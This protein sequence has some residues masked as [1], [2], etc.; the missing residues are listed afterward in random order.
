MIKSKIPIRKKV[1]LLFFTV[2]SCLLYGQIILTREGIVINNTETGT[3]IGDN[4]PR[5]KPTIFTYRNNSITSVNT[6]G[7][8]LQAGDEGPTPS[9]NNLDGQV[10]TGNN[11]IWNGVNSPVVLTHGLFV[12]YNIN[13]TIKYNYLKNVPYGIIFKSG[14]DAGQNMTFTSGGCAYNICKNGKFA[15]RLKGINGVHVYNN[16]FYNDDGSGWYFIFVSANMDRPA[17]SPSTG[18]KIFNNLFY[19]TTLFPMIKIESGCLEGFECD[20]NVYWCTSGEPKFMIDD[21]PTSWAEWRALGYDTHSIIANPNFINTTDLVPTTRLNYGKNLGKEWESGLSTTASW[22]PGTSP[23]TT[24]QNATWQVGARVY[25]SIPVTSIYLT[26]AEGVTNISTDE[27]TLQLNASVS[28]TNATNQ[29]V[30]WSIVNGTGQAS[31]SATGLVTA[32]ENGTVTAT[33]TANDGSGI[34]G[35]LVITISNQITPV[36]TITVTGVDGLSSITEDKGTLQLNAIVLPV[37][38]SNQIV[39]WSIVEGTGKATI[40]PTGL[41]T[42]VENGTVTAIAT[43]TDGSGVYGIL[44]ITISNQ[45]TIPTGFNSIEKKNETSTVIVAGSELK[46]VVENDFISGKASL[47]NSRGVLISETIFYNDIIKLNVNRHPSGLY[48]VLLSKGK[49]SMVVKVLKL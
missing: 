49:N 18:S 7:Y 32:K 31:I 30:T 16:T 6:Q 10:V 40:N 44:V 37:K 21:K 48:F 17:K 20:Y 13:S 26:G 39:T 43:A 24:N 28:P 38:A 27:G 8:M 14:T 2:Y 42:A 23:A 45:I 25:E 34:F 11:F 19:S 47:F 46:I 12:G 5:S 4:I 9:N 33:A 15:I 35:T 29:S 1:L 41:V 22:V 3:W 36:S